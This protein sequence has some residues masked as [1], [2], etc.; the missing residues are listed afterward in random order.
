MAALRKMTLLPAQ[1]LEDL[2]PAFAAKGRVRAGADADLA[3][4]DPARVLDRATFEDPFQPSIGIVHTL[5]GGVFV[6]KDEQ[7]VEGA[8]PGRGLRAGTFVE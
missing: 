3:I 6:V 1:R 8:T 2:A 4:F 7:L 5:V